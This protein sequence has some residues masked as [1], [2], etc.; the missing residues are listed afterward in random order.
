[1]PTYSLA[2]SQEGLRLEEQEEARRNGEQIWQ[3]VL[4]RS[5]SAKEDCTLTFQ[6]IR[7][8]YNYG[9][10]VMRLR[11]DACYKG[12]YTYMKITKQ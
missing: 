3:E 11:Y 6:N 12:R 1:M 4:S 2:K 9:T 5:M 8:E 7:D 10:R